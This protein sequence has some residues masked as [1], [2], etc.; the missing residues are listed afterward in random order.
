MGAAGPPATARNHGRPPVAPPRGAAHS[1]PRSRPWCDDP[2]RASPPDPMLLERPINQG[3]EPAIPLV[4]FDL[5][6]PEPLGVL[7]EPG[8]DA[9]H[10]VCRESLDCGGDLLDCAHRRL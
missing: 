1:I 3:V 6:V 9:G 8:P 10:L 4:P 7:R 5:L 2:Q